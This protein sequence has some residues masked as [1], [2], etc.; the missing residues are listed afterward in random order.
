M[1]R[2]LRYVDLFLAPLKWLCRFFAGRNP[3]RPTRNPGWCVQYLLL[4]AVCGPTAVGL[5][6]LPPSLSVS[7]AF[8]RVA[9]GCIAIGGTLVSGAQLWKDREQSLPVE[10]VGLTFAGFGTLCY[11]VALM[12]NA[13]S[14][15]AA[16]V[17]VGLSVAQTLSS[18]AR[19]LQ[20]W[21]YLLPE[22]RR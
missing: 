16:Q 13:S 7:D 4:A 6:A 22:S 17:A 19:Y 2:A 21:Y 14:W 11:S 18:S 1:K 9:A 8:G 10:Q 15:D 5:T 20:I 3:S 12:M